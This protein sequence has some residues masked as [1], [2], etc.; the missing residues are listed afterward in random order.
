[1]RAHWLPGIERA[2]WM[3]PVLGLFAVSTQSEPYF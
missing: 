2:I 3:S 1:M